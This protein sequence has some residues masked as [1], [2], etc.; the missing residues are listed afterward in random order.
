VN[1]LDIFLKNTQISNFT[2]IHAL[3]A[4]L[5]QADRQT[6]R[7]INIAQLTVVF[8]NFVNAPKN[9]CKSQYTAMLENL[10]YVTFQ[11]KFRSLK[12]EEI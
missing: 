3:G 12:Q 4:E 2:K 7:K 10:V 11:V 8:H 9:Q 1:F 5:F 6:E